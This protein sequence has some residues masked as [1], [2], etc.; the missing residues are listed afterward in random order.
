MS[1]PHV[2]AEHFA[3]C[4]AP[5]VTLVCVPVTLCEQGFQT[6][7]DNARLFVDFLNEDGNDRAH[8]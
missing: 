4:G 6:A 2:T 8:H 1:L 3:G 7:L 5:E